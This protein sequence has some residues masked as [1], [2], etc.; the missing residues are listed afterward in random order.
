MEI[1]ANLNGQIMP[2][3]QAQVSVLDRGFL[4][5][6]AV[7]EGLHLAN[8]RIRF[9][10]A[11]FA[12]LRRSLSELQLTG[13]DLDRL[14]QRLQDTIAASGCQEGF[15]YIQISRG[16]GP[17]RTHAFPEHCT[18]TELIFIDPTPDPYA[19]IRERGGHVI[20]FPDLRW[21]R[22][23]IKTV[24][25]LGNV[26]AAQAAKQA[27]A[28]EAIL[29]RDDGTLSEGSRTSVF[30]VVDGIL[31]TAP[32][33]PNILPGVTRHFVTYMIRD[34]GLPL[35]ERPVHLSEVPHLQELFLTGTSAEILPVVAVDGNAISNG[36]PGPI[37]RQLQA[38]FRRRIA[39]GTD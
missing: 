16:A 24:N 26:L 23:D 33:S 36:V 29:V 27:G 30:G 34:L 17:R 13:V 39:E 37:T 15:I 3:Q 38:E 8:G 4:F 5:G 32:L 1:L 2:L 18:P 6:D 31:R 22:C 9:L 10:D 7:Y 14:R 25:L 21:K 35:D 20:T 12:R 11:H 19:E 28:C